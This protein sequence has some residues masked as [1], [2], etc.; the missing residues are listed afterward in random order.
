MYA[1]GVGRH[2]GV[3]VKADQGKVRGRGG[4]GGQRVVGKVD[5]RKLY[6]QGGANARAGAGVGPIGTSCYEQCRLKTA[7]GRGREECRLMQ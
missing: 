6:Q 1:W 5:Q 4:G 2:R 7:R 3:L